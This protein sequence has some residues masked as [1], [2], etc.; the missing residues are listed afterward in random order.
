MEDAVGEPAG[1]PGMQKDN[2]SGADQKQGEHRS[3]DFRR[4]GHVK[5]IGQS[6]CQFLSIDFK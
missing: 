2:G 4:S 6:R 5:L 1:G 3:E